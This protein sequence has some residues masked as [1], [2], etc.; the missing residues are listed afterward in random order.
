M[1]TAKYREVVE[2]E[3]WGET[4]R[5]RHSR[6]RCDSLR[7][8]KE[9]RRQSYSREDLIL[10][11]KN[12]GRMY[13]RMLIRLHVARKQRLFAASVFIFRSWDSATPT[14]SCQS[15]DNNVLISI[16]PSR[17]SILNRLFRHYDYSF[18]WFANKIDSRVRI[19]RIGSSENLVASKQSCQ[20]GSSKETTLW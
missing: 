1:S 5:W 19:W 11:L 2:I 7:T 9:G 13:F 12:L 15:C 16:Y 17:F 20:L 14:T 4:T 18:Q 10:S 8:F 6:K 3:G